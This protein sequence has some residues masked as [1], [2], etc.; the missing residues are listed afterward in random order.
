M[1][2]RS[3]TTDDE[4][5]LLTYRY[6][7]LDNADFEILDD[8]IGEQLL[9]HLLRRLDR[10]PALSVSARSSSITLPA[11]TSP[12]PPPKPRLPSA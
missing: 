5:K 7:V 2:L 1:R 11:R 12:V 6:H 8:Q 4:L 10:L 9:S 3:A